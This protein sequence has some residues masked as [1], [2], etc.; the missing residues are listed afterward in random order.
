MENKHKQILISDKE[1]LSIEINQLNDFMS[2]VSN[3][4]VSDDF[5]KSIMNITNS[6]IQEKQFFHNEISNDLKT[7]SIDVGSL[8]NNDL[9]AEQEDYVLENAL[10]QA[11]ERRENAD[12]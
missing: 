10:E 9:T 7:I 1:D 3:S 8:V 11:R 6:Q 2:L 12:M 4:K 5:K